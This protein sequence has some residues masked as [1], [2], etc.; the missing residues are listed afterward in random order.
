M[1]TPL[2]ALMNCN[3]IAVPLQLGDATLT[4]I[5][6]GQRRASKLLSIYE[7]GGCANSDSGAAATQ[8]EGAPTTP[9]AQTRAC[10]SMIEHSVAPLQ[11]R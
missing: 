2:F 10:R 6:C 11:S 8:T 9:S 1:P 4:T 3:L 5:Y 7:P